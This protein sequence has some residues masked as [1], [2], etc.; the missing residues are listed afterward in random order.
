VTPAD[1]STPFHVYFLAAAAFTAG[2][3]LLMAAGAYG[4]H[5]LQARLSRRWAK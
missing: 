1:L 2:F 3:V 5:R 4:W